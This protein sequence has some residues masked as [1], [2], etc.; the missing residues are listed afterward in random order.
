MRDESHEDGLPDGWVEYTDP[1]SGQ[2]Y[3]YNEKDGTTTWDKPVAEPKEDGQPELVEIVTDPEV[4]PLDTEDELVGVSERK[5][6]EAPPGES[7]YRPLV[8][9]AQGSDQKPQE[10]RQPEPEP[11]SQSQQHIYENPQGRQDVPKS[12]TSPEQQPQ[13]WGVELQQLR[14][15]LP[16]WGVQPG[17]QQQGQQSDPWKMQQEDIVKIAEPE[18]AREGNSDVGFARPPQQY[19]HSQQEQ[20]P[21]FQQPPIQ[22]HFNR[23]PQLQKPPFQQSPQQERFNHPPQQQGPPP[24]QQGRPPQQ[25]GPPQQQKGPP[26]H[27]QQQPPGHQFGTQQQGPPPGFQQLPQQQGM[28]QHGQ[29]P[30]WQQQQNPHGTPPQH[31]QS[32]VG[33]QYG[34]YGQYGTQYPG[35][36]NQ[37]PGQL[38]P[39]QQPPQNQLIPAETTSAVKEALG[40][41]W[42]GL[43]GFG[44]RTKVAVEQARE[45]VVT[46]ATAAGQTIGST[47]T[48]LWSQARTGVGALFEKSDTPPQQP[49]GGYSMSGYGA[50]PQQPGGY[51][52]P[53]YGGQGG[54]PPQ[55]GQ[56]KGNPP[57]PHQPQQHQGPP[58]QGQWRGPPTGQQQQYPP[59][60]GPYGYPPQQQGGQYAPHQGRTLQQQEQQPPQGGQQHPPQAGQ[61]SPPQPENWQHPGLGGD[62]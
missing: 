60:G 49:P 56:P 41:T 61:Q 12:H 1:S 24:Q 27:Q 35:Q 28:P 48:G 40:K 4:Q 9:Y 18:P 38:R 47:T 44:N 57:Y 2:P 23:P 51:P 55:Y 54:Y 45:S 62:Y 50:P 11:E 46:S 31:Q 36:Y 59:R 5:Y 8:G 58:Q 6:E 34:Q 37:Y 39:P 43:L 10:E 29:R 25:L 30:P 7:Y 17:S 20:K 21:T 32:P 19:A 16:P 52:P 13:P 42:Q 33:Q 22:E 3:Y 26:L 14:D 53:Q 15:Q